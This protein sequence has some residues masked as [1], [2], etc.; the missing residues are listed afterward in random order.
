MFA[1]EAREERLVRPP[2]FSHIDA[3]LHRDAI[4]QALG[5]VENVGI[6][7]TEAQHRQQHD[8]LIELVVAEIFYRLVKVMGGAASEQPRHAIFGLIGAV[9]FWHDPKDVCETVRYLLDDLARGW[10]ASV[11]HERQT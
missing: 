2:P 1:L 9:I 10:R 3:E 4:E 6:L 8:E 5:R 11:L 7:L